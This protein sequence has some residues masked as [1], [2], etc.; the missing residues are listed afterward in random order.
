MPLS[1]TKPSA[2]VSAK[3][4]G[5]LPACPSAMTTPMRNSA[6]MTARTA[7]AALLSNPAIPTL[8]KIETNA[9]HSAESSA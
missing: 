5:R 7:V 1:A 2:F 3:T 8:P 6:M 9:A 4:C